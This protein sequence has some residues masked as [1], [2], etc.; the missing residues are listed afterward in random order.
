MQPFPTAVGFAYHL[1]F[2]IGVYGKG[3]PGPITVVANLSGPHGENPS[4]PLTCGP[5]STTEAGPR[6]QGCDFDFDARNAMT[7]LT[8]SGFGP[9]KVITEYIGLDLVSVQCFAPLGRH[10]LCQ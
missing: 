1:S 8:I 7:T 2:K 5:F 3:Y 4:P 9:E 6:W 10:Y